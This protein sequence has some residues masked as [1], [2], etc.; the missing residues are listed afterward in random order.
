[1]MHLCIDWGNTRVKAGLFLDNKLQQDFNFSHE[2][3]IR[4]I[5][6]ILVAHNPTATILS[7]VA[8]YDV[9]VEVLLSNLCE[10]VVILN[11]N[12]PLPIM[13]AYQSS[14]T[15]GMDRVALAVAASGEAK[16]QNCL[17]IGVGTAITYNFIQK[18]GTFRG[19][20]IS[21]GINM[22]FKAM[23][24]YAD[25]LPLVE[26]K[27]SNTLLGYDTES[28]IRSGVM[29]GIKAEIEGM[30]NEFNAQYEDLKVVITGGD[31][32]IFVDKLKNRIFADPFF[33]LKGL[34][35]ILNYN[36]R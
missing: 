5:E 26:A 18:T 15:L 30:I 35:L 2:D 10:K 24:E 11:H 33:L 27:G 23:H 8:D 7:T 21:P 16:G 19:G 32:P 20:A 14:E 25:R 3:A 6:R 17:V 36:V 29:N 28:S 13:N 22:R 31:S 34:N 4:T 12:T 9:E 1:M